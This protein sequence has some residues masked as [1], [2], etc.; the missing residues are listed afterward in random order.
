MSYDLQWR[1]TCLNG[2]AT[3][4][5][6]NIEVRGTAKYSSTVML[7]GGSLN[8][9]KY[10]INVS[11]GGASVRQDPVVISYVET[12]GTGEA[13]LCESAWIMRSL[14]TIVAD[15]ASN[16]VSLAGNKFTL[17][18]G[19][20]SCT[21]SSP[22]YKVG[23]NKTRLVSDAGTA[24]GARYSSAAMASTRDGSSTAIIQTVIDLD[25]DTRMY[26][27]HTCED[28]PSDGPIGSPNNDF[29]LGRPVAD[30][31]AGNFAAG[32]TYTTVNCVRTN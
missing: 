11:R 25:V 3:C 17:A 16:V 1:A 30:G 27:E 8:F 32:V 12:D 19:T 31:N 10:D 23:T 2:S 14:N 18:A 22:A 29:S 9:A 6:P 15:G 5:S 13:G 4:V 24:I 21:I 26:V 28:K 7:F 20:Y